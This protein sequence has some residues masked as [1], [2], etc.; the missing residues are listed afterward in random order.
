[1]GMTTE[2]L[3]R[4]WKE[5]DAVRRKV[6]GIQILKGMEVDILRDGRLDLP[7]EYLAKL[8]LVVVGVHSSMGM[9][10]KNMTDRIISAISHPSVH[11]L[12]HPASGLFGRREP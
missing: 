8:D 10:R 11:L 1:H 7:D 12:A 3:E 9:D 4:Q 2:R 5:I 6:E